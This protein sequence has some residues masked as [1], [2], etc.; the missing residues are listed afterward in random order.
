MKKVYSIALL[1]V[2]MITC[3]QGYNIYLQYQNYKLQCIDAINDVLVQSVDE[4]YHDRAKKK[5]NPDKN[6][7]QHIRYKIFHSLDQVPE[8]IRKQPFLN[9]QAL[10]IGS[11]KKRGII[12]NASDAIMLL[13]QDQVEKEGKPINLAKLDSIVVRRMGEKQEHSI[14]LLDKNKRILKVKGVTEVPN[15]WI[16]SK[17]VAV[18]LANLRFV[19]VAMPVAPSHFIIHSIWTLVLSVLFLL[20]AVICIGY[21]LQVIKRKELLLRNRELSVNGII[22]DLKAPINS[23]ISV[24]SLLKMRLGDDKQM[25]D[26]VSLASDKAKLLVSDIESILLAAKGSNNK[27]LLNLKKVNVIDVAHVVKTDMD[28]LYKNKQHSI[29]VSADAHGDVMAYADELYIR[30]VLRN[31]VENALK[32]SDEGVKVLVQVSSKGGNV[33]VSVSDDGWGIAPKEQKMIFSQ[34]YRVPQHKSVRGYGIGL[35]VAKYVV[36]AHHGKIGVKSELGKGSSFTFS[37]P[38]AKQNG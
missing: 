33:L 2:T 37:L 35:A 20:V 30:N 24:L 29:M 4:E 5:D 11:L 18:N 27:V 14:F 38:Q 17:D 7:E 34:F 28:I 21:H 22:H 1:A 13:G 36:E 12:S 6:G 8:K 15:S 26:V 3:L 19:R 9:L 23:V 25:L 10:D 32:Y 16:C 31:L